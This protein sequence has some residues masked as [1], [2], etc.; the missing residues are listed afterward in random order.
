MRDIIRQT[1]REQL[2]VGEDGLEGLGY[3]Y[4][5]HIKV[6]Q[7]KY[8]FDYRAFKEAGTPHDKNPY[9][10]IYRLTIRFTDGGILR[11]AHDHNGY[12]LIS[13]EDE[14]SPFAAIFLKYVQENDLLSDESFFQLL[15]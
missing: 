11:F 1:L 13:S 4:P 8:G 14:L 9:K 2:S 12:Q 10:E 5:E 15:T 7:K 3:P 6:V